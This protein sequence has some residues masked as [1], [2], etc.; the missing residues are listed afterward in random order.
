MKKL[1]SNLYSLTAIIFTASVITGIFW[2][3][4][5]NACGLD[6]LLDCLTVIPG[7]LAT[8]VILQLASWLTY[9]GGVILNFVVQ[10]TVVNMK[11]HLSQAGAIDKAWRTIRDVA[12]MGFIF[13][14]LY[15]AIKTILG[16]GDETRKLIV[17]IIVVAVLINFSLFFTKFV[18]D[19]SNMLAVTFYDAVAPGATAEN[20]SIGLSSSL[21]EPLGVQSIWKAGG[22]NFFKGN[23]LLIIG[24]MGTIMSLVAAFVFFAI[25]IL[26]IIRFVVLILVMVLSPIA[27]LG[28]ILPAAETYR[29]QWVDALIGQAFFAPIYFMLTWIVI[30]ISR[31]LLT[32]GGDLASALVGVAGANGENVANP[33][34]IGLL[35]NFIIMIVLLIASIIIAK[36]FASKT[37]GG[38]SKLMGAA[39]GWAG[40]ATLGVAGRFGRG[41]VGSFAAAKANDENLKARA[42][43]GDIGARLQLATANKLAKSSFDL[44]GT[45]LGGTLGAGNAKKGG[46]LQD[47]KDRAKAFEKY[48]PDQKEIDKLKEGLN[49]E[50]ETAVPKTL[51]QA[52]AEARLKQLRKTSTQGFSD[53]Q[54]KAHKA[55]LESAREEVEQHKEELAEKRTEYK[56]A[57]PAHTTV[58]NLENSMESMAKASEQRGRTVR[59]GVPFTKYSW[60][61]PASGY[62]P[63]LG[64]K[65]RAAAIRA[66]AK[67]KSNKEKLAE[68]AAAVAKEDAEASG[69]AKSEEKPKEEG[70]EEKKET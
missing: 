21:M 11:A 46:F 12:N 16:A 39:M 17:R 7:H 33:G 66:A 1:L 35:V 4:N 10:F 22:G 32:R 52:T 53:E 58:K 55:R 60:A 36:D 48:K 24:V 69:E 70:G 47:Q 19:A 62:I 59:L 57:Q 14:L 15:A 25:S 9:I 56:E 41:T 8:D 26:L 20:Y 61:I 2:P 31:G 54:I 45:G 34:A 63:G 18:I 68:A 43:A 65:D 50:A 13:I 67:G 42:R 27:F 64:G 30:V 44:R 29:K 38:V 40:G 37:P 51:E 5:A 3:Q 28:Y 6:G 49:K 23:N